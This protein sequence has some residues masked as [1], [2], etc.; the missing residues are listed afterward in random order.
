M[1][2][3]RAARG[4]SWA[5]RDDYRSTAFTTP[6]TESSMHGET[7]IA[8]SPE[9][10]YAHLVDVSRWPD[11][12]PGVRRAHAPNGI[13]LGAAFEIEMY[14]IRLEAVVPE[15]ELNTRFGWIGSSPNMS[16][17]QAWDLVP[18]PPGT[19]VVARKVERELT[20]VVVGNSRVE[21]LYY[22]HQDALLRLKEVAEA[23]GPSA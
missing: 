15:Y 6:R 17:Y 9:R 2:H 20:T 11:W 13:R 18:F 21:E 16:I 14:G 7:V 12:L 23:G 5:R 19:Q 10:V 4:V 8:A 3:P 1:Q 22:A